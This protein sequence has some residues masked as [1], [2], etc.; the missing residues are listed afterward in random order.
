MSPT[1]R[2]L[3]RATRARIVEAAGR[4]TRERGPNGFSMD[5]LAKEAGVARATVYEHFRSKRAVLDELA[6]SIA[7]TIVLDEQRTGTTDPLLA[8]RDM[9]GDVCRHWSEHEERIRGLRTLNALTGGEHAS[10]GVDEKQ[11]RQL[12]EALSRAGQLRPHWS[13][14]EAADALAALTSYSTYERLRRAPR[15]PEQVEAVLAKLV[16]AIVAP[17]AMASATASNAANSHS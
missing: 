12:V 14:E 9:L 3:V 5:V 16:V 11:L 7:R 10:D 17:S 4:L 6:S 15:T 2:E 8:L 13:V 1:R